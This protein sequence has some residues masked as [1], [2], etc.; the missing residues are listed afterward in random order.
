[1]IDI[2][3]WFFEI[4]DG[5][6]CVVNIVMSFEVFWVYWFVFVFKIIWVGIENFWI[7]VEFVCY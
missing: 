6:G 3:I 4:L 5:Y 1:M 2:V 7:V